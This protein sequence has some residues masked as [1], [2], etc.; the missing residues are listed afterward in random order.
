MF[1]SKFEIIL[2]LKC[3]SWMSAF[4]KCYDNWMSRNYLIF[5]GVDRDINQNK[6]WE[7]LLERATQINAVFRPFLN[8]LGLISSKKWKKNGTMRIS[9]CCKSFQFLF[10]F[11]AFRL[12]KEND[13]PNSLKRGPF[14]TFDV[15]EI[16]MTSK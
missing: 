11:F 2:C 6:N 7:L 16:N 15:Q 5:L 13:H 14:Q 8:M 10:Y 4:F 3:L 12:N 9:H 1:R